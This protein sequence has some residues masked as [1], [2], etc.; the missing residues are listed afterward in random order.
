MELRQWQREL[1]LL[2]EREAMELAAT[3]R[4]MEFEMKLKRLQS[5][6]SSRFSGDSLSSVSSS[7]TKDKPK[8][9]L[10]SATK[11]FDSTPN[12]SPTVQEV[13]CSKEG[14]GA[15]AAAESNPNQP[16][17]SQVLLDFIAKKSKLQYDTSKTF[18][19]SSFP[20]RPASIAFNAQ[21]TRPAI[22]PLMG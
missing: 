22:L 1:E 21:V 9:L 6:E 16:L 15:L 3:Q 14:T 5:E 13:N 4:E 20:T 7:L 2:A 17:T 18:I 19:P 8:N 11:N 12:Q 10:N